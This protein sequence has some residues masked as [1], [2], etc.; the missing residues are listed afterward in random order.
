MRRNNF[1]YSHTA[2][3]LTHNRAH[4]HTQTLDGSVLF[5]SVHSIFSFY[6][7]SV[8]VRVCAWYD[9]R[10]VNIGTW[11]NDRLMTRNELMA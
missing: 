6:S 3:E 8:C 2:F 10:S 1:F 5:C 11:V 7:L 4:H 9:E